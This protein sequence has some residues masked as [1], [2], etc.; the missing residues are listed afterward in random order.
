M[1]NVSANEERGYQQDKTVH[2]DLTRQNAA[3]G[4]RVLAGQ[5]KKHGAASERIDDGKQGSEDE[6][7]TFGDFQGILR[8]GEYSR[9]EA[10]AGL[11]VRRVPTPPSFCKRV[12]KGMRRKGIGDG[13]RR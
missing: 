11:L 5:S 9:G 7:D 6:Q 3:Y 12:R 4:V 10:F 2:G 13:N 8:R 1:Q